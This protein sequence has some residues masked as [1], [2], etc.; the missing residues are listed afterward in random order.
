MNLEV[1]FEVE[2]LRNEERDLPRRAQVG[3]FCGPP[4]IFKTDTLDG[5]VEQPKSVAAWEA[6]KVSKQILVEQDAKRALSSLPPEIQEDW[7]ETAVKLFQADPCGDEIDKL[8]THSKGYY[9][10]TLAQA[11]L[12]FVFEPLSSIENATMKDLNVSS[13]VG[14]D[15][16]NGI[17][18]A[19]ARK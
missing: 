19:T 3:G 17:I 6:T 2:A 1:E 18:R 7:M 5:A 10:R 11:E 8:S 4:F 16:A 12:H 15:V 13:I 14:I 9:V